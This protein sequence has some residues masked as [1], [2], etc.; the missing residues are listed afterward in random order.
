MNQSFSVH[1][2]RL[3]KSEIILI[4]NAEEISYSFLIKDQNSLNRINEVF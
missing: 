3:G 1:N 2:K 4:K